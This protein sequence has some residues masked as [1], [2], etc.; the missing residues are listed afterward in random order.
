MPPLAVS[1]N[2]KKLYTQTKY[3]SVL[4]ARIQYNQESYLRDR[5]RF[6]F[7]AILIDFNIFNSDF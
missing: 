7:F 3:E 6:A 2:S 4:N 1:T 5:E